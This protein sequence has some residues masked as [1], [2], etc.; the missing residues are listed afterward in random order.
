MH[1]NDAVAPPNIQRETME[2]LLFLCTTESP[3]RSP[4][5]KLCY[6][7]NGVARAMGSPLGP[8]FA[9]YYICDLE[10][11]F[12]ELPLETKFVCKVC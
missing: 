9:E 5:N 6:Q 8:T 1:N 4:H 7:I 3:F 2:S 10:N 12:V 11:S